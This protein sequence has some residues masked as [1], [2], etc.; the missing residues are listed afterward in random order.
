MEDR[1]NSVFSELRRFERSLHPSTPRLEIHLAN[2]KC[3]TVAESD[4]Y[5][6]QTGV[7]KKR[8]VYLMFDDGGVLEY[9]GVAMYTFNDRIWKHDHL[10]TRRWTDVIPF[11]DRNYYLAPALEFYLIARLHPPANSTY[12]G[13]KID[14]LPD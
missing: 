3:W 11:T 2:D 10:V 12:R 14:D 13:Y 1:W 5:Y 9:V 8:G 6:R 4:A 7:L